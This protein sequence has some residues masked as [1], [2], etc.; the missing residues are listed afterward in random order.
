MTVEYPKTA[1]SH[2]DYQYYHNQHMPLCARLFA[3][4]GFCG[5]VVRTGAGK[6]PGTEDLNWVVIDLLFDNQQQL[7]AALAAGGKDVSADIP[8]YTNCKPRMSFA[9]IALNTL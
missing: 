9:E 4:F 6:G 5:S 7:Q 8:N 2:F 1:D 3:D